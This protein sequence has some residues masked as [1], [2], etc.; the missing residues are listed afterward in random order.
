M[1]F[2]ET[3]KQHLG[4]VVAPLPVAPGLPARYESTYERH[5]V[6][7]LFMFF[8]PLAKRHSAVK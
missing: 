5:G 3:N 7:N 4:E 8:A 1:C 2:D 6:S